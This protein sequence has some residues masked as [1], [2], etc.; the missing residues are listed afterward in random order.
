M[1]RSLWLAIALGSVLLPGCGG[2]GGGKSPT[3]PT[4]NP[5]P[6]TV[7]ITVQDDQFVP[8]SV[9][10]NVGDTVRWVLGG[11]PNAGHTV[12][13][14][15]GSFDSGKVFTSSG[16][17][18]EHTFT[19]AGTTVLYHCQTHYVC[20]QMQGSIR[21]GDSAPPPPTGY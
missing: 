12:T 6:Q 13:A 9:N 20:C 11:S 16:A 10:I 3:S 1:R 4:T 14:N 8:K 21:V 17:V 18:F 15:D 2:G 5:S 19:A 7:V